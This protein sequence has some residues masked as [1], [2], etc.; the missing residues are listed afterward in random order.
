MLKWD[1]ANSKETKVKYMVR[2]EHMVED[3]LFTFD[4]ILY[5]PEGRYNDGEYYLR[6]RDDKSLIF[7]TGMGEIEGRAKHAAENYLKLVLAKRNPRSVHMWELEVGWESYK[8]LSAPD[9]IPVVSNGILI[10]SKF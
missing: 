6:I 7:F 2:A 10:R 8:R 3:V 9:F 5:E 4:V 1:N